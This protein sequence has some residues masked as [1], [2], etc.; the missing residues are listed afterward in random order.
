MGAFFSLGALGDCIFCSTI[1]P[2]LDKLLLLPCTQALAQEQHE[3]RYN[4]LLDGS[5]RLLDVCSIARDA[6]SQSKEC[7]RELQS[8]LC[9]RWGSKMNLVR[10]V[11]K[12][13]ASRKV[14]KKAMQ[15]VLKGM[16]TN[17]NS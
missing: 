5:L 3:K 10:E 7:T 17:L 14:V 9:R 15:K 4:E 11:E 2:A 6:L 1:Q 12:Y 8:T 13:L 16:Q